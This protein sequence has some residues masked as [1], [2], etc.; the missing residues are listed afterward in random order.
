M[1]QSPLARISKILGALVIM[2][3]IIMSNA[4]PSFAL[5][6][7]VTNEVEPTKTATPWFYWPGWA[8]LGLIVL[9][10]ATIG[11]AWYKTIF[12][13]KYRGQKVAQ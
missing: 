10:S 6:E 8:F 3:S 2:A 1:T 4:I 5:D 11:F 9:I 7:I 12:V 13:P